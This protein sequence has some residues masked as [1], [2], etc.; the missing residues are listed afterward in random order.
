MRIRDGSSDVCSSDRGEPQT[1]QQDPHYD[2]ASLDVYDY[3][4]ERV[5]ACVAAGIAGE[6]IAIDPGIGFGKND[7]HNVAILGRS[8]ERRVG[9]ECG[10]TCRSRWAQYH[11]KKN[12]QSES[13]MRTNKL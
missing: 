11:K 7:A 2:D 6:R 10:S 9:K 3:L 13:Y 8:E 1:M 4:A 12:E 5:A